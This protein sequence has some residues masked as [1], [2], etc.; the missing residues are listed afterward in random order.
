MEQ[1]SSLQPNSERLR[2]QVETVTYY[3]EGNDYAILK[4]RVYGHP[5]FVTVV[6]NIASPTPGE[7][8]TMS[9]EWVMHPSFGEQ[10]KV[11]TYSCAVPATVAGITKYLGS[12]L[13]LGIGPKMAK[14]I[15]EVFGEKTLDI[16]D[17]SVERLLEVEGIGKHRVD[18]IAKAWAEQREIR[19]VMVFLQS[20]GVS[21][22]YATKIYKRYG[23]D[24]IKIVRENPYR[25]AYDIWGIGFLTADKIAQN[26][27]FE[28]NSLERAA[29]GLMY[30][31][32]MTTQEG[33]VFF[34]SKDLIVRAQ[35]LLEIDAE[36]LEEAMVLLRNEGK[37]FVE[38]FSRNQGEKSTSEEAD[39]GVYLSK[40][41]L[42]E[43]RIAQILQEIRDTDSEL[44]ELYAGSCT[45]Y[46]QKKMGIQLSD[47]Q[48]EAV[49]S[50]IT[51]KI[52]VITGGPGTGKTTITR[53]VIEIFSL[54][55]RKIILAAP[56]GRAAKRMSEATGREAK[57][58]HRLLEF[59]PA[60]GKFKKDEDNPLDCDVII[61]DEASMIDNLLA[62]CLLRAI[63]KNAI[64]ILV[65][66]INQLPSV[67]AGN[68]LKDIINSHTF[69]VVELN[70][71]FRQARSST[72]IVNAHKIIHGERLFLN[73][74]EWSDFRFIEEDSAEEIAKKIIAIVK[75]KIP[76][77]FGFEPNDIQVLTPMNKGIIGSQ[78]LNG[79]LQEAL[80]PYGIELSRAGRKYRVGDKVM[81]IRNNYDKDVYN[82]D[83]GF[84]TD[85]DTENQVVK[86]GIYDREIVYE[87]AD[88]DELVLAYAVSIHK[89]QGSEYPVVVMPIA[90]AHYMMLQ[91]NLIY[92][93]VTR[94]KKLV[95]VVGSK[96][97]IHIA[98]KN[99]SV[100]NRNT[101]LE[102]R[103]RATC[104]WDS[105]ELGEFSH[106]KIRHL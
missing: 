37:I 7:I 102:Q 55:T 14:R 27:G 100:A 74:A 84:I 54:V 79:A 18:M 69:A 97:A 98:V 60:D 89:S 13:I 51:Q 8:L 47:K 93:G 20:N 52:S 15:V 40:Y 26:L 66:D 71:I 62:Y 36:I 24:A 94:G 53:V 85:I 5:N 12:G 35:Q 101:Y 17:E 2:G 41:Y 65:G 31:L 19:S 9:G 77:K 87:Y 29:A 82:G 103:I 30:T 56:T 21:S 38:D 64:V 28:R 88:L 3:N 16:I 61:I 95:V 92:T 39:Q 33:H 23:N 86:V 76:E 46:A 99:D 42:A 83:I 70:E 43:V 1:K 34:Q 22:T 45:A 105:S 75:E 63:P 72:I 68:V 106:K 73:N 78:A 6:G 25:L 49:E 32:Q 4:V 58:I 96:K 91:R 10:F 90:M 57:T 11:S 48:I 50:A 59:S 81:Q 104:I 67:G 44:D 80:N